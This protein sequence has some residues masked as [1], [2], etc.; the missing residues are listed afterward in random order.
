[1][2]T[3]TKIKLEVVDADGHYLEPPF[4]IPDYIE[5]KYKDV[6]PRIVQE[7]GKEYWE[8]RGWWDYNPQ[9]GAREGT[10]RLATAV[11]G[12]AGV[13]RWNQGTSLQ[14]IKG[15]GY[16]QINPAA[17]DPIERI[18]VMDNERIDAAVLYPTMNLQWLDDPDFQ[19]AMN[20]ALNDWQADYIKA[21]PRRLYGAANI[22][23]IHDVA[24][25]CA[26]VRR[27]VEQHGFKAV[28]L[29]T[30]HALPE[31]RWWTDFY[32]PFWKTCE[33]LDVAIGFHPFPGDMMYGSGRFFD[34]IGP[35][36]SQ[37]LAR[38]PVNH[39]VDAMHTLAGLIA[40]G[41]LEQFPGLRIAI[42]ESGGGWLVSF[43]ER[44]D[45]RFEHL[46]H[47]APHV[48]MKPSDY[49]R[50][51][52]WIA[53]DPDEA[54]LPLTVQWLGADRIIWGSDF[55]HPDAFYPNFL[56]M[57]DENIASL[58]SDDRARIR[59]LNAIDFYKLPREV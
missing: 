45:H 1:M 53:F 49:F 22:V 4:A 9:A 31:A 10:R 28:F 16:T 43:L 32:D 13:E 39:P 2:T 55:P 11:A 48:K 36:T 20:R 58:S 18:K 29:R 52:A 21:A 59:G 37:Q 57:L 35:T 26:E 30:A 56:D 23:A 17:V 34:M 42:L 5:P 6:A 25:A 14:D 12:L 44:M 19:L 8:G 50:R 47:L 3:Q 33:D 54:A 24:A 7:D 15:L 40:G 46:G 51:Q 27:C 38:G 41:K